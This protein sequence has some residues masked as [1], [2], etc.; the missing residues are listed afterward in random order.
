M[1]WVQTVNANRDELILNDCSVISTD[2]L[3]RIQ[4]EPNETLK[5]SRVQTHFTSWRIVPP[6][7]VT[8]AL[9]VR[10]NQ[11][12]YEFNWDKQRFWVPAQVLIPRLIN[13]WSVLCKFA[14]SSAGIDSLCVPASD[15]SN[16]LLFF[17]NVMNGR[18]LS[19][20][21]ILQPLLWACSSPSTRRAW[22]SV[23]R[24]A[25]KGELAMDLPVGCA[26]LAC[27]S[28]KV[29]DVWLVLELVVNSVFSE[30]LPYDFAVGSSRMVVFR[31][32]VRP[33]VAGESKDKFSLQ[34]NHSGWSL[35]DEEWGAVEPIFQHRFR[36]PQAYSTRQIL[37]N[38]LEKLGR[39]CTWRTLDCKQGNWVTA[40][41]RYRTY[42]K[43]G[44]LQQMLGV[45]QSMREGLPAM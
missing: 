42:R 4:V 14:L 43:S 17:Q 27:H 21:S 15:V 6:E 30:E 11:R 10:L 19:R 25:L 22:N 12:F 29:S 20:Q 24:Y 41:Q 1:F 23:H 3:H 45:L 5:K 7:E 39:G 32:P 36:R 44:Q 18:E 31:E 38:I 9:G 37:D 28:M 33:R 26:R 8:A 16:G 13:P 2:R 34:R 35:T 40:H